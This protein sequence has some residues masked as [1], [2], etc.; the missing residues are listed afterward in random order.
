MLAAARGGARGRSSSHQRHHADSLSLSAETRLH[1]QRLHHLTQLHLPNLV[2]VGSNIAVI[3]VGRTCIAS[4]ARVSTASCL[5][6]DLG[7]TSTPAHAFV[8]GVFTGTVRGTVLKEVQW[9][10]AQKNIAVLNT[11]AGLGGG[12]SSPA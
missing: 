4:R 11:E 8:T 3:A 10:T 5:L 2:R 9:H 1:L 6:R 12:C 7:L